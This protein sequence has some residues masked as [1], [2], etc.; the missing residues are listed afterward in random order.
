[1]T[2]VNTKL[3]Y[4]HANNGTNN[5]TLVNC[6]INSLNSNFSGTIINSI[7][8]S[9]E[10]SSTVVLNTLYY[11]N[12]VSIYSNS[13]AQNCY[14]IYNSN[15]IG[16]DCECYYSTTDLQSNGY[17]GTDGTVVGINGGDTP[18]TLI[19]SVPKVTSSD[20]RVDKENKKLNVKLTVSP[21]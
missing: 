8:K 6:N 10:L 9:G 17:L 14:S 21:Q 18:F 19:P 2:V 3:F 1:M 5:T 20:I 13:V 4:V 11:S 12:G 7:I 15:L 16:N